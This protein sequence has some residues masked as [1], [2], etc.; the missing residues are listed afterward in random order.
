MLCFVQR[1]CLPL[2]YAAYNGQAHAVEFLLSKHA[3]INARNKVC[4]DRNF[5]YLNLLSSSINTGT[6]NATS[7]SHAVV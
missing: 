7:K 2:H 3:D 1:G 4:N 5:V 6:L